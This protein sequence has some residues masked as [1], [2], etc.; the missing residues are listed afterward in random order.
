MVAYSPLEI[1]IE[2]ATEL[3]NANHVIKMKVYAVL[4]ICSSDNSNLNFT[5]QRTPVDIDG[6]SNPK[7]NFFAKFNVDIVAAQQNQLTLVI[8]LKSVKNIHSLKPNEDVDIGEVNVPIKDFLTDSFG[9][10]EEEEKHVNYP[11]RTMAGEPKGVLKFSYK[12][13]KPSSRDYQHVV[14]QPGYC[15]CPHSGY[16]APPPYP[17]DRY[18]A[19]PPYPAYGHAAPPTYPAYGHAAQ[20]PYPAY[21]HAAPLP[22]PAYGH[23]AQPSYPP[24]GHAAPPPYGQAAPPYGHAA[25]QM[26]PQQKPNS[27]FARLGIGL[28]GGAIS[29]LI[30]GVAQG[31]IGALF[32]G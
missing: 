13:G 17:A 20:P 29:G 9:L 8:K 12:L 5:E 21:W 27:I 1:I 18:A 30:G 3:E 15:G 19:P 6:H 10:A 28:A 2:S 31:G 7:W 16:A 24:Y 23:A 26:Q 22:Y 11:V 14:Q 32:S 25:P 4:S